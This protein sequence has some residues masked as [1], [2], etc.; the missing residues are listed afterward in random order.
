MVAPTDPNGGG[1]TP[2]LYFSSSP[3]SMVYLPAG[4]CP[5]SLEQ[6][7][8]ALTSDLYRTACECRAIHGPGYGAV[9]A[10][11]LG[12]VSFAVASNF[13]IHGDNGRSMPLSLHLRFAGA[14]LSGKSAAHVRFNAPI[15]E[16]MK[17]WK[18]RWLFD[19][20][21][22][23][24]YLRRIRA[25]SVWT[26]FSM[27]EGRGHLADRF[28]RS[29]QD[30]SDLYDTT[31]PQ[32]DRAD[33]DDDMLAE[34]APDSALLVTCVNVQDDAHRSWLDRY[35]EEAMASGYLF[36]L[37][38]METD[39]LAIEGAAGLQQEYA[40]L[41]Y[42]HRIGEL[43][44]SGL[45]KLKKMSVDKLPVIEVSP[46][47]E[48]VLRQARVCFQSMPGPVLSSRDAIVFAVRL[49]ANARRIAGCMHV[50]EGYEGA[51]TADTMA[52][53]VT[54]AKYFGACWLSTVFPP[55]PV[56]DAVLRGQ[57]LLDYLHRQ[58]I[59]F[60]MQF[61]SWRESDI[62]ALAPNFGWNK[63]QI[64]EAI[65]LICGRG[66]ARVMPRTENG[67]RIIKLELISAR[68]SYFSG[69]DPASLV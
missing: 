40:L 7:I 48:Q 25:G 10:N 35:G 39:E 63:A 12:N 67:R 31:V 15:V 3:Q 27:S 53:A 55:K 5:S 60:G 24:A 45:L 59:Q 32:F 17:D 44:A 18:K 21:T 36:R 68:S 29:F 57:Y 66:L 64:R 6:S 49:A 37:L 65:R 56:P 26:M 43:I 61:P 50:Y 14:R 38:M 1:V 52:R 34:R 62:V 51:V 30:F 19:N 46:D 9:L 41:D 13:R 33:D 11:L 54:I 42:D 28:S 4:Y 8:D 69:G 58:A 23:A 47:A 16:A 20:T 2:S 22:R